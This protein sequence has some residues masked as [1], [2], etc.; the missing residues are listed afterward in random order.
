VAAAVQSGCFTEQ[1]G[2]L[3]LNHIKAQNSAG[4]HVFIRTIAGQRKIQKAPQLKRPDNSPL[5]LVGFVQ[6]PT[7]CPGMQQAISMLQMHGYGYPPSADTG[8]NN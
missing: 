1:Q 7:C 8:F 4:L 2:R 5:G 6:H 3:H